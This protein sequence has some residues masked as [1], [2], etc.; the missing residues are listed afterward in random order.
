MGA[1]SILKTLAQK[2]W[3]QP[4]TK[5]Y[6]YKLI[7]KIAQFDPDLQLENINTQW[8]ERFAQ[9]CK[10]KGNNNNTIKK[11]IKVLKCLLRMAYD[12]GYIKHLPDIRIKIPS[13]PVERIFLTEDELKTLYDAYFNLELPP[14]QKESLRIFLFCCYTGLRYSDAMRLKTF[15]IGKA[16]GMY[17]IHLLT[18]KNKQPIFI[19]IIAPALALIE[20]ELKASRNC[21]VFK[22]QRNQLINKNLK[23]IARMVGVHK[24]LSMHV[25]RRTF[26]TFLLNR[27]AG[28]QLVAHCL[29][30]K[31]TRHVHYYARLLN[32]TIF[33]FFKQLQD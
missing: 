1:F 3:V 16:H 11:N 14:G 10:A 24:P 8:M 26:A 20:N 23:K 4:S 18:Q 30:H 27:G 15:H 7:N 22:K 5:E 33:Q 19:P 13:E 2:R 31:D 25:A 6:Y 9:W 17:C 28:V 12:Y 21:Y 29:G 32:K